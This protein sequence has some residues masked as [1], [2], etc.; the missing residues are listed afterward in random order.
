[1]S[2]E[3][4]KA[5]T[6]KAD[7]IDLMEVFHR[8]WDKRTTIYKTMALFFLF[9]L[10][11]VIFSPKVY[12]SEITLLIESNS[13]MSN[14]SGLL[15]QFGG[16]AGLNL[17]SGMAGEDALTPELYPDIVNYT[18]FII[19]LLNEKIALSKSDTLITVTDY[20]E[21]QSKPSIIGRFFGL[22]GGDKENVK[23]SS[24][25]IMNG[26]YFLSEE[27]HDMIKALSNFI[28]AYKGKSKLSNLLTVSVEMHDPFVAAQ[29]NN[30][31]VQNLQ[32]YIIDYR[33]QKAKTDLDFVIKR[34]SEAEIRYINAAQRL[35]Q[36]RD[37]H[38]NM[39]LAS[40]KTIE[41]RLQ[42]EFN[43]AYNVY[44]TLSQQLE[45]SKMKVQENTPVFKV[46]SP[47]IIPLHKYKPKTTLTL[48]NSL[49]VGFFIGVLIIFISE[50]RNKLFKNVKF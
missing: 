20:L 43:L 39:V 17:S 14:M 32:E 46:L 30:I 42:S 1:M 15:Q 12:K 41:E 27:K 16:L 5:K 26:Y 36:F 45:Q 33:T 35:A 10:L 19:E 23:D 37:Q 47:A 25:L 9:G 34:H 49:V 28:E 8:I 4:I 13:N 7:E 2:E 21:E 22:F 18:P 24:D 29:L 6:D 11:L 31:V 40:A 38:T 3:V 48:L 50:K 44:N